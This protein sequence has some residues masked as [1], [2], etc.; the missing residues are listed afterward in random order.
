[1]TPSFDFLISKLP[2]PLSF[3][4]KDRPDLQELRLRVNAPVVITTPGGRS[5]TR[6][7]CT[8]ELLE[9]TLQS[10]T[11][12]SFYSHEDTI[13]EGYI[14]L[15]HGIRLGLCGRAVCK[16]GEI[17]SVKEVSFLCIRI[18]HSYKGLAAPLYDLLCRTRF[19]KG[20]LIYSL[21]GVGKT[22]VLKDLLRLLGQAEKFV[23]VIDE[24][25]EFS[26]CENT[27][28]GVIYRHYPKSL[29]ISMAI[30]TVTPDF[31]LLDEIGGAECAV[32]LENA[33]C[34]VPIIASAHAES[35]KELLLRPGF[36][37]LFAHGMFPLVA[38][39]TRIGTQVEYLF[40]EPPDLPSGSIAQ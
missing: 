13:K 26:P 21:P 11:E 9:T 39:I 34:G 17:L 12:Y 30:K 20:L 29:A 31:L 37:R 35:A 7:L 23:A 16:K 32:L 18:P 24:R 6:L 5:T 19:Q 33:L 22:T 15:P 1:M 38:G 10:L 4:L 8:E 36:D 28:H 27:G 40:S 3:L 14:S 25:G 2:S